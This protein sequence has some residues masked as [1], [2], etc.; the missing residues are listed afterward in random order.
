MNERD[1]ELLA[2]LLR[3]RGHLPTDSEAQA[4]IILVNTC[5]VRDQAERKAVG[6]VGLFKR[7]KRQKP[8]LVI[9]II[10][11]MAQAHGRALLDQLPH[12]DLVVG[13][14]QLHDIPDL[15][16][17][18][19]EGARAVVATQVQE[20][21]PANLSAHA[22]GQVAASVAV[23]RGCE[24]FCSYCIVPQTRG[25]E[26]SRPVED[27]VHEVEELAARGTREILLLGQNITAYG[28]AETRRAP[29]A[30]N[31]PATPSA[32]DGEVGRGCQ[33]PTP[34]ASSA[35]DR[36]SPRAATQN[37]IANGIGRAPAQALPPHPRF[38]DL[39]R[40]VHAV[41]GILRIRF[42]SPHV[43]YMDADFVDCVCSLPKVCKAFHIPV[44]SGSDR[45]L[46]LMHRGYTAADYLQVVDAIRARL[47]RVAFST[48]VI[49][50][51]PSETEE[52]FAATRE[53]MRRV[54]F[55]MAYIFKYSPRRGTQAAEKHADD[56]PAE[57]KLQRNQLLLDDLDASV[58]ARNQAAV[59]Q[60]VEVLAEGPSRRNAARWQ[61]RSDTHKV[62][63]FDPVGPL[64]PG[65]LVRVAVERATAHSLFGSIVP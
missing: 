17:S 15:I 50:G 5:S 1:S 42:T 36:Q 49:V 6:K 38:A 32:A 3:D 4:D 8:S 57:T 60:H 16:D 35:R 29:N 23:M 41:P 27:I 31:F 12:V 52:D 25:R 63:I 30:A 19:L 18:A 7:L 48:D 43:R 59:G 58:A 21:L 22:P 44:Q 13:P 64:A 34:A 33:Y 24:Q 11:C 9:G 39:L 62:V 37:G 56:V 47:D 45:I 2:C 55:D 10:G 46:R 51:F 61:G 53:L 40:A 14:D 20:G 26:R 54:G 65:A 28:V